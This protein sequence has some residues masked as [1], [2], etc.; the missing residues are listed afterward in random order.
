MAN[1][2]GNLVSSNITG[3]KPDVS[4]ELSLLDVN[5]YPLVAILTNAG[6]DPVT[7]V[8][9]SMKKRAVSNHEFQWYEKEYAAVSDA[10]NNAAGYAA[11]ATS[12]VVDNGG[13]FNLN[14]VV[15][16]PRTGERMQVTAI[17][18]NTL[19]VTRSIGSTAAAALVDDDPLF[20]IGSAFGQGSDSAQA[21]YDQK[22][23]K[24]NYTQIFKTSVDV[25]G[26]HAAED[27]YTGKTR[28]EERQIKGV[29]HMILIERAFMFGEKGSGSDKDSKEAYYTGGV[30]ELISTNVQDESSSSLTE[31]E[32]ESFLGDYAFANGSLEKYMFASSTVISTINK[33]A[34][35]DLRTVPGEKTFGVQIQ[36]YVSPHGRLFIAKEPLLTGTIYGGYAIVLDMKQL[37]YAFL[38]GRDTQLQIGVQASGNDSVKDQYLTEAGLERRLEKTHALLKGVT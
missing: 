24:T 28:D 36:E 3:L 25:S 29:E 12:V 15:L 35:D 8:G 22:V 17:S 23:N 38:Q 11:S 37:K 34:R 16:V 33:F 19:T 30:I 1:V 9:K 13:Y 6:R 27:T 31:A 26:T 18:S 2:K 20:L 10:I 5:R 32:F 7:G 14:D 4:A 21:S